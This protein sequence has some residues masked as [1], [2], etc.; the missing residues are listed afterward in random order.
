MG[1]VY[2]ARD[3]R[4]G[5]TVAIKVL[6]AV[7]A[8]DET[9]RHRLFRE[10]RAVSSIDHPNIC[11]L[12]DVGHGNGIDYL[13][14]QFLDG[15]SLA[16][17]LRREGAL[18]LD[19]AL[20]YAREILA[21]LAAAHAQ[22][23]VHR[24]LKPGNVM[25]TAS[26]AKLLDFGL[27]VPH[28]DA[29]AEPLSERSTQSVLTKPG[30]VMGTLPYMSPE[31]LEGHS[32][33][34]R[35][36]LFSF[37]ALFYEMLTGRRA[38]S[39]TADAGVMTQILGTMPRT[40]SRVNPLVPPALDAV[41]LRCLEKTPSR[42]WQRADEVLGGITAAMSPSQSLRRLI[43]VAAAAGLIALGIVTAVVTLPRLRGQA[44]TNAAMSASGVRLLAVLPF[45]TDATD[46]AELAYWAGLTQTVSARL[47]TLAPAH[48]LYVAAAA[49]VVRRH[50]TTPEEGRLE[51]GVNRAIRAR[52][53]TTE[54]A[55]T[56]LELVDTTTEKTLGRAEVPVDR[57]NP[58]AFQNQVMD[59]I[60][61]LLDISLTP[62][63]RA[64][65]IAPPA[66]PGAYELYLQGVG[67]IDGYLR[68]GNLDTAIG[69]LQQSLRR[70]GNYAAAHAALGRAF[71]RKY[72]QTNDAATAEA[73]RQACERALGLD[74]SDANSHACLGMVN[75]GIG[76]YAEAIEEFQHAMQRDPASEE[77][78]LG[79]ADAYQKNG[80][81]AKAEEI[82]KRTLTLRPG[83]PSTYNRL[84]VFYY[85]IGRHADA[86]Q[87]FRN[88][89]TLAPDSWR[90]FANL[91]AVLYVQ[92]K[93]PEAISA[94]RRSLDIK[95]NDQAASNLGTLYFLETREYQKA[96]DAFRQA[97]GAGSGD[98][99]LWGNLAAALRWA[100]DG[101]AAQIAYRRAIDLAEAR[102]MVNP[103]DAQVLLQLAEYRAAT[104]D[105]RTAATLLVD[106][107]K[108][109]E[110]SPA[111]Q[112]EAALTYAYWF[113]D[114]DRALELL[115]KALA[116]GHPWRAL[117]R[118]P[119]LD[120]L[121]GDRRFN[122][123]RRHISPPAAGTNPGG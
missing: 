15:E 42:R 34:Q 23:I 116:G 105:R 101:A 82:F 9:A 119:S 28:P 3:T 109:G 87:M 55:R 108:V 91:G 49:D 122:D 46:A 79:L 10:A 123:L 88:V 74:E 25:I 60:L 75:A 103:R 98:P 52:T 61:R 50:V 8:D 114:R 115:R 99:L 35:S 48:R 93:V 38:F 2:R 100:G 78:Y 77:A 117:E 57:Q 111:L 69:L 43:Y 64:R 37:G 76:R 4:L 80:D 68:E 84:G 16:S 59:A 120:R 118:S 26:G 51:L 81:A 29:A 113:D 14:M 33:D 20:R 19:T 90:G 40:P 86:E 12:Y 92:G 53:T 121:R 107:L 44:F 22:G 47:A 63:E 6:S 21:A 97:I 83:S 58:A 30:S 18:D 56:T 104:G 24:D 17:R 112:Y 54:P 13:V 62:A 32:A 102:R 96:A 89:T 106:G 67:H 7:T 11:A 41:V 1:E 71:W 110:Q 31:Q 5:R 65:L 36:D 27:A 45:A 39:A 72:E 66:T 95:P 73:A 70:D 85:S 94:C